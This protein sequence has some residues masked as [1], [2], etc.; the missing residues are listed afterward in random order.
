[1]IKR[2]A[3]L[4]GTKVYIGRTHSDIM[5]RENIHYDHKYEE[6]F[7]TD[8]NKFVNRREAA[9]IAFECGQIKKRLN[10]LNSYDI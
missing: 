1:M 10:I 7:V 9:K 4:R 3:I 5:I 6:G 8:E 2:A